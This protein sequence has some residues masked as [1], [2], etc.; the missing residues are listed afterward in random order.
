MDSNSNLYR[1]S[2]LT[3]KSNLISTAESLTTLLNPTWSIDPRIKMLAKTQI[4]HTK[5]KMERIMEPFLGKDSFMLSTIEHENKI[6][7]YRIM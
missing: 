7:F 1:I 4:K 6:V 5:T 2:S 3:T